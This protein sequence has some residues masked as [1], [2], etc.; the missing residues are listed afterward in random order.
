MQNMSGLQSL[1]DG[2]GGLLENGVLNC[3]GVVAEDVQTDNLNVS[4]NITAGQ[5]VAIGR[6]ISIGNSIVSPNIFT[7]KLVSQ[8]LITQTI[9]TNKINLSNNLQIYDDTNIGFIKKNPEIASKPF[10]LTNTDLFI[11]SLALPIGVYILN[12]RFDIA[13]SAISLP[14]LHGVTHALSSDNVAGD[15]SFM[16]FYGNI[17]LNNTLS[18]AT[19]NVTVFHQV[20]EFNSSVYLL[21]YHE[22]RTIEVSNV[23]LQNVNMSALRIG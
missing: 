22:S 2:S 23:L 16:K 21:A 11:T 15:I 12:Y 1:D 14:S 5:S 10:L 3:V 18:Y 7:N 19:V 13:L 8:Q 6:D 20:K 4:D 9:K 17:E